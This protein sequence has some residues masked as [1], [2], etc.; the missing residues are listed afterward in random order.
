MADAL[1]RRVSDA[2]LC[3]YFQIDPLGSVPEDIAVN[4]GLSLYALP[5]TRD[6]EHME[7]ARC[8][9]VHMVSEQNRL[10]YIPIVFQVQFD[11]RQRPITLVSYSGDAS[12]TRHTQ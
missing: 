1:L 2:C 4:F 9:S 7:L 12:P 8:D 3:C 5:Y 11:T 10:K 6:H